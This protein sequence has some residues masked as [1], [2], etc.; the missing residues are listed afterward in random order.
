MKVET[1]WHFFIRTAHILTCDKLN[2]IEKLNCIRLI[3]K[4]LV[5]PEITMNKEEQDLLDR[6]C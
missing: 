1:E 4:E 5:Y 2:D 3:Y 6:I